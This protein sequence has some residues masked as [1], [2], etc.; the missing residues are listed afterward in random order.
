MLI[1]ML[2]KKDSCLDY[3]SLFILI[4]VVYYLI[5]V[6]CDMAFCLWVRSSFSVP[7]SPRMFWLFLESSTLQM[8][9]LQSFETSV[10]SMEQRSSWEP[11]WF[12]VGSQVIKKFPA[13]DGTRRFITAFTRT[14]HL[15]LSWTRSIQSMPTPYFSKIHFNII[16]PSKPES[17]KW[18]LSKDTSQYLNRLERLALPLW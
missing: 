17:S 16:L 11:V 13:F 10:N 4:A 2:A 6:L 14:H 18:Y 12:S 5:G 9:V 1:S 7:S 15:S 8:K 3:K